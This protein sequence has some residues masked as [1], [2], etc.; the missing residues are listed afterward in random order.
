MVERSDEMVDRYYTWFFNN[1]NNYRYT[2]PKAKAVLKSIEDFIAKNDPNIY[3]FNTIYASF[4][5]LYKGNIIAQVKSND[6]IY[7]IKGNYYLLFEEDSI[8]VPL[9]YIEFY[10]RVS[11]LEIENIIHCEIRNREIYYDSLIGQK[12]V[13]VNKCD[14]LIRS[15]GNHTKE[16]RDAKINRFIFLSLILIPGIFI[17]GLLFNE[18]VNYFL[19]NQITRWIIF[20]VA[21]LLCLLYLLLAWGFFEDV[22]ILQ[23]GKK[24]NQDLYDIEL[25]LHTNTKNLQ[26]INIRKLVV[27]IKAGKK[28]KP[29]LSDLDYKELYYK[30]EDQME[31]VEKDKLIKIKLKIVIYHA[32]NIVLC[33]FSGLISSVLFIYLMKNDY[34]FK[35]LTYMPILSS[36]LITLILAFPIIKI[37]KN[38]RIRNI[39]MV[40]FF[41][42]LISMGLWYGLLYI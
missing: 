4:M 39:M 41:S 26:S 37:F 13:L 27:A 42:A 35:V 12:E 18:V 14:R 31:D 6:G 8:L 32:S 25:K 16:V 17:G 20:G 29:P 38:I 7:P 40:L 11:E 2:G 34:G 21:C 36:F 33:L 28:L 5:A 9:A 1:Y 30:A 22:R 24:I 15:T 19:L 3:N 23:R 10:K